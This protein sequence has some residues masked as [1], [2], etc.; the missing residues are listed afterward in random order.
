MS[1]DK[2][3]NVITGFPFLEL[4]QYFHFFHS[5]LS[6]IFLRNVCLVP[7]SIAALP[8]ASQSNGAG[9]FDYFS[10]RG[11]KKKRLQLCLDSIMLVSPAHIV[12]VRVSY[13]CPEYFLFMSC[14]R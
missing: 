10:L 6:W 7:Q 12:G 5:Y 14:M 9:L 8:L 13:R 1:F 4:T 11:K 3:L 2:V